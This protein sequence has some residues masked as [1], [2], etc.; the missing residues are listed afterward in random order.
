VLDRFDVLVFDW[1]GTL[2]DSTAAIAESIR[3]AARDLGLA[4]PGAE[5]A[6]HVI[7]LGLHDAMSRAVP[8]LRAE[9]TGEFVARYR[10]HFLSREDR[11]GL[12]ESA[13]ELIQGA[14]QQGGRL[15]IATGKSR[16]GLQRSLRSLDLESHFEATR[17]ADESEPKPSPKM[18]FELAQVMKVAPARMLMIGDTT[19][20]LLMAR[21]AGVAALAISHGA[22]SEEQLR[23]LAPLAVLDSLGAVQRWLM[24]G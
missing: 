14:R 24:P 7:G 12:F 5:R 6:A 16:A 13:R 2:F 10:V 18:L 21:A 23:A 11:L 4:D 3:L 20:D 1:D 22:H 17:C 19:H 9:D 15:A 8:D